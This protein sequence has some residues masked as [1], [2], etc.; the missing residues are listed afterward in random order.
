MKNHPLEALIERFLA[1]KN[2]AGTTVKSYNFA[3]KNFISYLKENNIEYAKTSDIIQ[4]RESKRALGYSIHWIYIQISVLKG[5]YHYLRINQKHLD[6]PVEYAYDIMGPIKNERI[7]QRITKPILTLEQAKRLILQTKNNRKSFWH[8]RDHAILYLMITTGLRSIEI[9]RAKR[10]DYQNID[11]KWVLYVPSKKRRSND[12][13]VKI[14]QGAEAAMRDYLNKRKDDNPYLFITHKNSAKEGHLSR[15]FFMDMF[16]RVLKDCGLKDS[17]ITPHCLRH[18][19]A[20]MNLLRGGSLEQTRQLLRHVD[21]QST[22]VYVRHIERMKDDSEVQ[23]ESFILKEE[24]SRFDDDFISYL[25]I[26]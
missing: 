16:P 14:S 7:K 20:T 12:E 5:L 25:E 8:Y 4:Y 22:L 17:G 26:E 18:T 24:A 2:I 6:L 13:F 15:T 3:Y 23:I 1:E 9:L 21:I 10:E 19:A 11:G